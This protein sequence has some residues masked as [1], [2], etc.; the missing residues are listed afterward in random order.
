MISVTNTIVDR[1]QAKVSHVKTTTD[2]SVAT[3]AVTA[4]T[5]VEI[6]ATNLIVHRVLPQPILAEKVVASAGIRIVMGLSIAPIA[7]MK[8]IARAKR[9]NSRVAQFAKPTHDSADVVFLKASAVT[10]LFIV[11]TAVMK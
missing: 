7:L 3:I 4:E 6:I 9:R 1:A 5:I 11:L 8:S 10:K 2:A